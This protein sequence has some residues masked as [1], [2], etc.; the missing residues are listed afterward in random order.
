MKRAAAAATAARTR[1]RR[2]HL[3]STLSQQKREAAETKY[4]LKVA[5]ML[6]DNRGNW[7]AIK[8][9]DV[10]LLIVQVAVRIFI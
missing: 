8:D 2:W 10:K 7:A 9:T 6:E 1:A 5:V 3:S 4:D